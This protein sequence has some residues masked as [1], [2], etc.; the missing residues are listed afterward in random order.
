MLITTNV[1]FF[2]HL[3]SHRSAKRTIKTIVLIYYLLELEYWWNHKGFKQ[4][5]GESLVY[6]STSRKKNENIFLALKPNLEWDE[7]YHKQ[8]SHTLNWF[9]R[10]LKNCADILMFSVLF[11]GDDDFKSK[12]NLARLACAPVQCPSTSSVKDKYWI[13]V[14]VK[15][16]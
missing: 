11:F 15:L 7:P 9:F 8:I 6:F 13:C 1:I 12:R 16:K 10:R 3:T 14:L 5:V 4:L 2:V